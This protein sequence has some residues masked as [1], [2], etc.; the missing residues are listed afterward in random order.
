M[1]AGILS[2]LC[3]NL[4]QKHHGKYWFPKTATRLPLL[5]WGTSRS[6]QNHLRVTWH[7]FQQQQPSL[8]VFVLLVWKEAPVWTDATAGP[9]SL[10]LPGSLKGWV[11]QHSAITGSPW[12][13]DWAATAYQG[14]LTCLGWYC[15]GLICCHCGKD[16]K[17]VKNRQRLT[18]PQVVATC[19]LQ[20]AKKENRCEPWR[21]GELQDPVVLQAEVKVNWSCLKSRHHWM[22]N[23]IGK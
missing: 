20:G 12:Y 14:I 17:S 2:I 18:T 8:A 3:Q 10:H 9:T 22:T 23:S 11:S 16:L 1:E 6:C 21:P 4:C 13:E 15:T 5:T 7:L 19:R